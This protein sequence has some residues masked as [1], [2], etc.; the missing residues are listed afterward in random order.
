[1]LPAALAALAF[2][3]TVRDVPDSRE[4]HAGRFDVGGAIL[5]ALAIGGLVL[6]IHEGPEQGWGASITVAGLAVGVAALVGFVAWELRQ[7]SPLLD[8]RILR[9]RGLAAG[10]ITMMALFAVMFGLFLVL[11]QYL[12]AVLGYSAL[13]AAAGLLPL[14]ATMMPLSNV[15]PRLAAR[16][17]TRPVLIAGLTAFAAGLVLLA[18]S[19]SV[20]GGYWAVLPG[21]VILGTG[22]GLAMTPSTTAITESLP[23]E[24]QGVASAL[25]D[26]VREIGGALGVALLGSVLNASY[27]DGVAPAADALPAE[28]GEAVRDGIG[29][30]LAVAGQLGDAGPGLA[31]AA[32]ASFVD[33]WSTSMWTGLGVT[34]VALAW[35]VLRGRAPQEAPAKAP[36]LVLAAADA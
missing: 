12:Q 5:S 17:G 22:M 11:I 4:D 29:G 28:A 27:R 3:L 15:S 36:E 21:L 6:A 2:V 10:S 14:A 32:R 34:V 31:D 30:A 18:T 19:A 23:P 7:A 26:T 25:N 9:H 33:A 35:V 20:D 13:G 8:V 16:F 1:V 24:R